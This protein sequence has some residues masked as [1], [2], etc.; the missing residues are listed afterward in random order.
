M[1]KTLATSAL[2]LA[3]LWGD[4]GADG[5]VV[6]DVP[7]EP[8]PA[9]VVERMLDMA[10]VGPDDVVFDLGSGDGRIVIAAAKRGARG[11]GVEVDPKLVE[12]ARRRAE[13]EDVADRTRF[14]QQDLFQADIAEATVVTLFLWPEVNLRLRPK[15]LN[16]LRPGTRV[17]SHFHDME[18]WP[19]E[20]TARIGSYRAIYRWTI[21]AN[22][23]GTW[24]GRLRWPDGRTQ[25]LELRLTQRFSTLAGSLEAGGTGAALDEGRLSGPDIRLRAD[26]LA[27]TGR[28]QGENMTGQAVRANEILDFELTRDP[29]SRQPLELQAVEAVPP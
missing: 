27:L 15:L 23:G 19:A 26:A 3:L 28:V 21:P 10:A 17:I 12:G 2:A 14:L 29:A 18:D 8:S 6:R 5:K 22:A 7:Y 24:R 20:E 11:V 13:K 16:E 25:P 9:N 1:R 4:A